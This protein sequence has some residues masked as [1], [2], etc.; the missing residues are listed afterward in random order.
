MCVGAGRILATYS[1]PSQR[2][3]GSQRG[4]GERADNSAV[5]AISLKFSGDDLTSAPKRSFLSVI[6]LFP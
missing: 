3:P 4:E 6:G 2:P 1:S 5:L